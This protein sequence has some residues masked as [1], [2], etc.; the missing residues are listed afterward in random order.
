MQTQTTIR[1]KKYLLHINE[2]RDVSLYIQLIVLARTFEEKYLKYIY[3]LGRSMQKK[4][5][6]N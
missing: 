4:Y 2:F 3:L 6:N 5:Q 1:F